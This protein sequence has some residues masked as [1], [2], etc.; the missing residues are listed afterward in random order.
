MKAFL[1]VLPALALAVTSTNA[2][3]AVA[4]APVANSY[5]GPAPEP[6][7]PAVVVPPQPVLPQQPHIVLPQPQAEEG[8]STIEI[9]E[10]DDEEPGFIVQNGFDGYIIPSE[11][12]PK[13][14]LPSTFPLI[15]SL[16]GL[17]KLPKFLFALGPLFSNGLLAL[18]AIG[19]VGTVI[20]TFTPFCGITIFGL[21]SEEVKNAL[22]S[23]RAKSVVEFVANSIDKYRSLVKQIEDAAAENVARKNAAKGSNALKKRRR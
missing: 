12:I 15:A 17:I 18:G 2:Y 1:L 22:K 13:T 9:I 23:E 6:H 7:P 11:L 10:H 3:S 19:A 5:S 21:R 4:P 14:D 16:F 8:L 20:C